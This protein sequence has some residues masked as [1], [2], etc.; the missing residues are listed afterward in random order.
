[1]LHQPIVSIAFP[2]EDVRLII[3]HSVDSCSVHDQMDAETETLR[4]A[5]G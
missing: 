3:D 1:M 2:R 4:M 5:Q